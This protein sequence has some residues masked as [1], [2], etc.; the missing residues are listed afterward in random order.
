VY[1]TG[2]SLYLTALASAGPDQADRWRAAKAAA[3]EA[4][5]ASGA[6][7]TH[8]HGVGSDHSPWLDAEVGPAGVGLLRAVKAH[9]DP[10]A[11]LNPGVLLPAQE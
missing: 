8:H 4:I 9:L 5:V 2:A 6:T 1:E 11:I 3:T 7:I 10:D